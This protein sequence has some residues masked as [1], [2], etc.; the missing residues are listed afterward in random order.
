LQHRALASGWTLGGG[1]EYVF[2]PHW[3]TKAEYLYYDLGTLTQKLLDPKL[4]ATGWQQSVDF[5]GSIV[6]VGL[7]FK[8]GG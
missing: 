5:K 7:N 4:P 8:F 3:S 6:R 1:A 2:A